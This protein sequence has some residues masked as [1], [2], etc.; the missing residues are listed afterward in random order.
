MWNTTPSSITVRNISGNRIT[1]IKTGCIAQQSKTEGS[2]AHY[3]ALFWGLGIR[4]GYSATSAVQILTSYCCEHSE[5][6]PLSDHNK[7]RADK[8][9]RFPG[10]SYR[11]AVPN[12]RVKVRGPE[13]KGSCPVNA[14]RPFVSKG[15]RGPPARIGEGCTGLRVVPMYV[16][17]AVR[18]P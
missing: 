16:W 5:T 18:V 9:T 4:L 17:D 11:V 15:W 8:K 12:L 13:E 14:Y 6:P 1:L 10:V 2:H 3:F 7:D